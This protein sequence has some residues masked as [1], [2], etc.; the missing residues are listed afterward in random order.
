MN[1]N[2]KF[3]ED[4]KKYSEM[5]NNI[6]DPAVQ[7]EAQN[8]LNS[9][10]TRVRNIDK[11]HSE[12]ITGNTSALDAVGNERKKIIEIRKSLDNKLKRV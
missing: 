1:L 5:I 7:K 2:N 6:S 8:L 10:S 9:L 12:L 3:Q 4:Y 11:M